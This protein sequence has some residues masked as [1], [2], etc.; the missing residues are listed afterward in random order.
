M[1]P[2]SYVFDSESVCKFSKILNEEVYMLEQVTTFEETKSFFMFRLDVKNDVNVN[3]KASF[4]AFHLI[5]CDVKCMQAYS[6]VDWLL[7]Q[8]NFGR[9]N[10]LILTGDKCFVLKHDVKLK[11]KRL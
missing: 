11:K 1:L 4:Q 8:S 7:T 5:L 2:N 9:K 6:Y 3:S 10:D